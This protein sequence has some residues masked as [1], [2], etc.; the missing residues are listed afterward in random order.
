MEYVKTSDN[1]YKKNY[2]GSNNGAI[3][4]PLV[5]ERYVVDNQ[6]SLSNGQRAQELKTTRSIAN[7]YLS[8]PKTLNINAI[9]KNGY[10]DQNTL[11]RSSV[12]IYNISNTENISNLSS[13]IAGQRRIANL[14]NNRN[15]SSNILYTRIS[16]K[17]PQVSNTKS[18][19][20][21]ENYYYQ[22]ELS[23]SN[24]DC[25]NQYRGK[26][27]INIGVSPRN[28]HLKK[29]SI[30]NLNNL[31]PSDRFKDSQVRASTQSNNE[32]IDRTHTEF[33]T[34][35]NQTNIRYLMNSL[36]DKQFSNLNQISSRNYT[37]VKENVLLKTFDANRN[38]QVFGNQIERFASINKN[39][40]LHQNDP[41]SIIMR[42]S[43]VYTNVN[44]M[45]KS[46]D[47]L[48]KTN[49][50]NFPP[51]RRI[52]E[53]INQVNEQKE[54]LNVKEQELYC[55]KTQSND[56]NYKTNYSQKA[57]KKKNKAKIIELDKQNESLKVENGAN[58]KNIKKAHSSIKKFELENDVTNQELIDENKNQQKRLEKIKQEI[59]EKL[60]QNENNILTRLESLLEEE[61]K[62]TV[63]RFANNKEA[64]L[65]E[66]S[67][68]Y[69]KIKEKNSKWRL[70]GY[71]K[72]EDTID[73][74]GW[75]EQFF[76]I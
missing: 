74:N 39:E 48:Q 53:L 36:D 5:N 22:S 26:N 13:N 20:D 50:E 29:T 72:D 55:I 37:P 66:F 28:K 70:N 58:K 68:F 4:Q 30:E 33:S 17:E 12:D 75:L 46:I 7:N 67:N 34:S 54:I 15:L 47:M 38:S 59:K 1:F 61:S 19:F 44:D 21:T 14:E 9:S 2:V 24:L 64:M 43:Q 35:K 62:A 73:P 60:N 40:H 57:V 76:G 51:V 45:K 52:K 49:Y 31:K 32:L 25:K 11:E 8:N 56:L 18:N 65:E 42:N 63:Y 16:G 3:K 71:N 6:K 10:N 69:V 27:Q 41:Q 23:F